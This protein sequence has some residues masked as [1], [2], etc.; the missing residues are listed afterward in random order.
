M[1]TPNQ[2]NDTE[3]HGDSKLMRPDEGAN[4]KLGL[5]IQNKYNFILFFLWI[6]TGWNITTISGK[7][8]PITLEWNITYM[9]IFQTKQGSFTIRFVA[10]YVQIIETPHDKLD[11][12]NNIYL[13]R[14]SCRLT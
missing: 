10:S 5:W 9:Y 4:K 7:N 11:T 14:R 8:G 1:R 2:L 13:S 3:L 6:P 12:K